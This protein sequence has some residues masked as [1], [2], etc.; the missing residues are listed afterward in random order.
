MTTIRVSDET[1]ERLRKLGSKGDS[2]EDIIRR[3]LDEVEEVEIEP[4]GE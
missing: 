3:L 4:V 1:H 2:Y